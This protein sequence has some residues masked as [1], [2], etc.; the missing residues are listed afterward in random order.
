MTNTLLSIL[1]FILLATNATALGLGILDANNDEYYSCK[2]T[3]KVG[4]ILVPCY[5]LGYLLYKICNI[6]LK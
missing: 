1:L 2:F 3:L 6:K 4:H 5:L